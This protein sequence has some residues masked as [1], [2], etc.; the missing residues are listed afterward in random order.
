M[1]QSEQGADRQ[2]TVK[3]TLSWGEKYGFCF[4]S[5]EKIL[6]DLRKELTYYALFYKKIILAG[7][8]RINCRGKCERGGRESD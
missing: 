6:E 7:V 8:C 5:D 4:K 2:G 1:V 3:E